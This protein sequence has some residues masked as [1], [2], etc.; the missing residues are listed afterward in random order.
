MKGRAHRLVDLALVIGLAVTLTVHLISAPSHG[1]LAVLISAALLNAL[2]ISIGFRLMFA[3]LYGWESMRTIP[4]TGTVT[5]AIGA[6][7]LLVNE[8]SGSIVMVLPLGETVNTARAPSKGTIDLPFSARLQ[9]LT[10]N[11]AQP[12]FVLIAEHDP[13]SDDGRRHRRVEPAPDGTLDLGE[14]GRYQLQNVLHYA[15]IVSHTL[16]TRRQLEVYSHDSLWRTVDITEPGESVV[17]PEGDTL[18]ISAFVNDVTSFRGYEPQPEMNM[19][20]P[21]APPCAPG[22]IIDIRTEQGSARYLVAADGAQEPRMIDSRGNAPA[23]P[24]T[25]L[26]AP[27][28]ASMQ[29]ENSQDMLPRTAVRLQPLSGEKPFVLVE[30]C[31]R[32]MRKTLPNGDTLRLVVPAPS[33]CQAVMEVHTQHHTAQLT[34]TTDAPVAFGGYR[35]ALIGCQPALGEVT[36]RLRRSQRSALGTGAF[37]VV[38][39]GFVL[40]LVGEIRSR[41]EAQ[42]AR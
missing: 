7:L 19:P 32:I 3:V 42:P 4:V 6:I 26:S 8:L 27:P 13:D 39:L 11:P 36:L 29:V 34:P 41:A 17:R 23:C 9:D 35:L 38:I 28:V 24:E 33:T 30:G 14:G 15:R 22:A 25:R 12:A 31:E 18:I 37:V 20:N 10:A 40:V 1:R 16:A 2:L 21:D 5:A